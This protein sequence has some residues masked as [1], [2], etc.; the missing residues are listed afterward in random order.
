MIHQLAFSGLVLAGLGGIAAAIRWFISYRVARSN[1]LRYMVLRVSSLILSGQPFAW[2]DLV[3][4]YKLEAGGMAPETSDG[5]KIFDEAEELLAA[6]L[7]RSG[8]PEFVARSRQTIHFAQASVPSEPT[9]WDTEYVINAMLGSI[10]LMGVASSLA[11]IRNTNFILS[12]FMIAFGEVIVPAAIFVVQAFL[13]C[14]QAT[15]IRR[16]MEKQESMFAK[17]I[18]TRPGG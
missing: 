12:D 1:L 17:S 13:V 10:L 8:D 7:I 9:P 15:Q 18:D 4:I 2:D 16:A 5:R 14:R 3:K 6:S 11:G